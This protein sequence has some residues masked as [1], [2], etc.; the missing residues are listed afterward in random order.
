MK[1]AFASLIIAVFL[2]ACV[3]AGG[4]ISVGS[5]T[6]QEAPSPEIVSKIEAQ[7]VQ[8]ECIGSL[9]RWGR[10]Y[11]WKTF[12]N[13]YDGGLPRTTQDRTRE[14]E[15]VLREAGKFGWE[16]GSFVEPMPSALGPNQIIVSSDDR[17][18][19]R[20]SGTYNV[21]DETLDLRRCGPNMRRSAED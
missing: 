15:F 12:P 16:A 10:F 20:A 2:G 13:D 11:R 4:A 5:L 6:P 8:H 14:V 1:T 17:Q 18:Y 21:A 9:D 19:L 7:L 3:G